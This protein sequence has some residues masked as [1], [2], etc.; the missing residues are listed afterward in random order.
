MATGTGEGRMQKILIYTDSDKA[1]RNVV[2]DYLVRI[3]LDIKRSPAPVSARVL[4]IDKQ[5]FYDC[6]PDTM[7]SFSTILR[8]ASFLKENLKGFDAII[9]ITENEVLGKV[10]SEID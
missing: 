8:E 3:G 5:F 4:A 2:V 7:P 6:L 9:I 10:A 1:Q